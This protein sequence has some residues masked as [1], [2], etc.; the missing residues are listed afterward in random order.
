MTYDD[1]LTQENRFG[2]E[3]DTFLKAW[4]MKLEDGGL[5]GRRGF[6]SKRHPDIHVR[7]V[8]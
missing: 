7:W 2:C 4:T 8:Y 5:V 1:H 3:E 6:H